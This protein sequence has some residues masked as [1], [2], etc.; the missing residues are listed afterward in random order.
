MCFDRESLA[1]FR[2]SN[3]RTSRLSL[4]SSVDY[5]PYRRRWGARCTYTLSTSRCECT[6]SVYTP[7]FLVGFSRETKMNALKNSSYPV[8]ISVGNV[9]FICFKFLME[10]KL[11]VD[12]SSLLLRPTETSPPVSARAVEL[13]R[14]HLFACCLFSTPPLWLC[15]S[16]HV[17]TSDSDK[18]PHFFL[19]LLNQR[20]FPRVCL[21]YCLR[22]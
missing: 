15:A 6:C 14:S 4:H 19:S 12:R 7:E 8:M 20:I 17:R 21:S 22:V 10:H 1:V 13:S 2:N 16:T 5:S 18:V 9:F 11:R 3:Y